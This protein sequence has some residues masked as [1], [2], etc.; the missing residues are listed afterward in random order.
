MSRRCRIHLDGVPLHIV[1]R[2][3]NREPCF[4]GEDDY[5]SYLHWLGEALTECDCELHAYVLMTNHVHLLLTPRQAEAVPKLIISLGRRYVQYINRSYH[6]TGTLWDSRYKSS[7]VQAE[8]YL[9]ACHRYI[10]MNPVRAAMVEDPAH[11]RWT[12]YRANGLGQAE[13]RLSPHPLYRALGRDD[14]ERQAAYRALF[15]AHL[16]RTA[17]DDIRLALQQSQPLGDQRFYATI[18]QQTGIRHEA[19]PRGR[20]R[21]DR[22]QNTLP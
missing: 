1:Q 15:A 21:M 13:A 3:H 10:E 12:S 18:E 22:V 17:I 9:L 11:Y 2:G 4:F 8:T 20:P 16:D 19:K 7:L 14:K 6:R 5:S